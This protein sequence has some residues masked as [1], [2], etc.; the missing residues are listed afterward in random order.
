[1]KKPK[2][3]FFRES[4]LQ[5]VISDIITFGFIIFSIWFSADSKIWTFICVL[6]LF[7]LIMAKGSNR[8]NVFYKKEDLIN[9]IN[10]IN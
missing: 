2:Y 10:G 8:K 4:L 6:F 9:Y 3:I 7:L 5:S 1:M